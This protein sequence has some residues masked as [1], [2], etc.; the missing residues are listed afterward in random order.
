MKALPVLAAILLASLALP[1]TAMAQSASATATASVTLVD[2]VGIAQMR[3]E[4]VADAQVGDKRAAIQT[5]SYALGGPTGQVVSVESTR[6]LSLRNATGQSLM[7]EIGVSH[8]SGAATTSQRVRMSGSVPLA[9]LSSPGL[10][11]GDMIV[12]A[13]YN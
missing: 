12:M 13:S 5:P 3:G 6:N 10:Y 9:R 2:P 1:A 4:A 11:T 8:L 7:S